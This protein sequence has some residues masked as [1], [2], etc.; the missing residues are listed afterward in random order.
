[1]EG[2]VELSVELP[3]RALKTVGDATRLQQVVGNILG[4]ALKFTPRGGHVCL[5]LMADATSAKLVITDDGPGI[6]PEFLPVVFDRFKQA[7]PTS[8]SAKR[9][10][11][12]GL[13]IVKHLVELHGGAVSAY[14]EGLGKGARFEVTLPLGAH[15]PDDTSRVSIAP[16]AAAEPTSEARPALAGI[17]AL[18]VED[19][20]DGCDLMQM[21][22]RRF[23]AEV[24][25][26][27]TAAAALESVRTRRPDVL[28]SDIGLPD[29][30]GF[31]LL[32]RVRESNKDLPA[33]AV[34]AY[35]SRQDIA[36]ALAA[37][38]QAHVAKPV[39]P[40]QLSAAVAQA[41]GR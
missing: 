17:Y 26:V 8:H 11:G 37:G 1:M 34:T 18:L 10:L 4:N 38:F 41:S 27:S 19:D 14:S 40:A 5:S 6:A 36:K 28:V 16:L 13:A 20:P 32:K 7:T 24:T 31:A 25:A 29:G 39:E 23:G 3:E 2:G 22:L 15:K 30:D 35:A 12:L 9:G 33:V 21:M